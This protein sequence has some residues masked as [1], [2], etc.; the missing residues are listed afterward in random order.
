MRVRFR[1]FDAHSG[2]LPFALYVPPGRP[3]ALGWPLILFLHGSRERGQDGKKQT[4]VGLGPAIRENPEAWP[5][6]VLMPQ[7]P[8][9]LT[10]Q[11]T[12]LETVYALLGEVERR[13]KADPRRI[14]LTGLSMGG[15]GAWNMAIRYPDKFAALAPICGAADPF[16]VMFNLGHL[17][18]WNFHGD[19]DAVVPVEFS[20]VLRQALERSGNKNYHFTEYA[21]VDHNSWDRAYREREFIR[22]LFSQKRG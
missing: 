11:G 22:W 14:Y 18:V 8:Q 6:L 3:P 12:V 10:W 20:R 17:P 16:A 19:A 7:C 1:Y 9:G 13:A 21:G 5:A 4:T 2:H 15:H